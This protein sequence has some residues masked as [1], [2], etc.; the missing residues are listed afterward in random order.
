MKYLFGAVLIAGW[1]SGGAQSTK[2]TL[3]YSKSVNVS[4]FALVDIDHGVMVGGEYRFRRNLSVSLDLDYIFY[5]N[6]YQEAK[7]SK[8][9]NV[10]PAFRYYFGK[11]LHEFVQLQ[12]FYKRV[13]YSMHGWLDKDCVNNVSSYS[14]LQDFTFKKNVTGVNL[15]VGDILP[16]SNKL[17]FDIGVGLGVRFKTHKITE[18]N[19]CFPP[20]SNNFMNRF[21]EEATSFSLPFSVKLAYIVD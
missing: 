1:L 2:K 5:S 19:A 3:L 16:L 21:S 15:M 12:A 20:Q 4:P 18:P 9:F 7:E 6:Y 14:Q 11:R 8:G 13:N 17:Y 10:R